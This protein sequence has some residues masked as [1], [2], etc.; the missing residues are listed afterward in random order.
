M[1]IKTGIFVCLQ[2][3]AG[4]DIMESSEIHRLLKARAD[5]DKQLQTHIN[6]CNM[7][8]LL[9]DF[10]LGAQEEKV[11][12]QTYDDLSVILRRSYP[13]SLDMTGIMDL[14]ET[15]V[16]HLLITGML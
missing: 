2:L 15:Y 7:D 6:K 11:R 12:K 3:Q 13:E 9:L 4:T 16:K 1:N 5:I 8:S 14:V 10:R